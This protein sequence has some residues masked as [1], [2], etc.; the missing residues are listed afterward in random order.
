MQLFVFGAMSLLMVG[1]AGKWQAPKDPSHQ[2]DFWVGEWKCSGEMHGANGQVTKT[3]AQNSITREYGG[4]V[5]HE[6]FKMAGLNGMSVSVY[7]PQKK[8]W[9]QTWADDG[10]GYIV[11]TGAYA[12]DKMTLATTPGP[13]G[14]TSRMVF[15]NITKSSF[16]WDWEG[17]KDS[18]KTWTLQWH[19]HY[20]RKPK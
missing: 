19:L 18:G 12:N 2:L 14:G 15:S 4:H 9:Q 11:L 6:H 20:V 5:I 7:N 1:G 10:G 8:I 17:S 16:D 3:N 13:K